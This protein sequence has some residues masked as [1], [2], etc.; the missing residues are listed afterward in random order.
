MMRLM[1]GTLAALLVLADSAAAQTSRPALRASV[2]LTGDVVRIGDL[3]ENA[4]AVA[5]I[6]IFRAPDLGTRGAVATDRV[7]E[8]IRPHQ[9]I[10]IDTRGL[11]EVVVTRSS[12]AIPTQEISAR[13]AQ[14]LSEQYALGE[15]RHIALSFDRAVQTLQVESSATGGLQ[16][17][18][19]NYDPRTTR[20]DV[21]LDLPSSPLLHRQPLRFTG[22]AIETID[23][24]A[25]DH[26]VERGA[27]LQASNLV[28]L[29][30]PKSQG[31]ALTDSA[32]V[33][34]LAARHQLRPGQAL[35]AADLMKPEII[36]RNDAVTLV[37]E[38][39]GVT[40]TLRGQAQDAGALG[41]AISVL[42]AQTKRI[43]QGIVAGPGQ[44]TVRAV[45]HLVANASVPSPAAVIE[46]PRRSE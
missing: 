19:L 9:L 8:A 3:V 18:A 14:A 35:T 25:V 46:P 17:L 42:N 32:A 22:T 12:R 24:L 43:V 45:T 27:V 7:I 29:R 5:D 33:V 10:D 37:Y 2:T 38:A 39:P 23:A 6:P 1:L 11:S 13:I 41:D 30:R 20:F 31:D 26:P 34:G 21:M 36:Q 16:V 4:G 40:L 15:P 28:V 44:V